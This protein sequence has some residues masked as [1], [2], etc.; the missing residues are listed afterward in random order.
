M[1]DCWDSQEISKLLEFA[2][3]HGQ[4]KR[5]LHTQKFEKSK[6]RYNSRFWHGGR[7]ERN[8]QVAIL[9]VQGGENSASRQLCRKVGHVGDRVPVL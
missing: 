2:S 3:T 1:G 4:K 6:W 7:V 5:W 9:Q 8:L